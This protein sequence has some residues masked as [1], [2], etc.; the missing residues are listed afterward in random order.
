MDKFI[1]RQNNVSP[2]L[3]KKYSL[4]KDRIKYLIA[5]IQQQKPDI[6]YE[7]PNQIILPDIFIS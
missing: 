4:Q 3:K 1:W 5:E 7:T 2:N 6:I